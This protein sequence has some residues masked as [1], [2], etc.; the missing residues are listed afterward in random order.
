MRRLL[1]LPL[2]FILGLII[3]TGY[4]VQT[5]HSYKS[6]ILESHGLEGCGGNRLAVMVVAVGAAMMAL[7][8]LLFP[9]WLFVRLGC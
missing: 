9:L 6:S 7:V 5:R 8:L 3:G 2:L 1:T 4:G